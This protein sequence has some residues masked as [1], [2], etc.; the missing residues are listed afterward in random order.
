MNYKNLAQEK[1]TNVNADCTFPITVLI[2]SIHQSK[3]KVVRIYQGLEQ[4][5][6]IYKLPTLK[7]I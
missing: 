5:F 3:L 6:P 1:S 4:Q 7:A 2:Q